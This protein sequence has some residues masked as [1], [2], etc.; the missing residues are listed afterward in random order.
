MASPPADACGNSTHLLHVETSACEMDLYRGEHGL[1][2]ETE[3]Y[4]TSERSRE[5]ITEFQTL[6]G[7]LRDTQLPF[8]EYTWMVDEDQRPAGHEH[9]SEDID[10]LVQR[11]NDV[12]GQVRFTM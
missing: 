10:D 2:L 9:F 1:I 12:A 5:C 6:L 8:C 7:R 3:P 11:Y 4:V